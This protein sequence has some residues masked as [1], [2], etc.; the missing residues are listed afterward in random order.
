MNLF[1]WNTT[2]GHLVMARLPGL[3]LAAAMALSDSWLSSN[4]GWV[5]D[6][7]GDP[8]G[9]GE[10]GGDESQAE[11]AD[12]IQ[13]EQLGLY[14]VIMV[15][16][17]VTINVAMAGPYATDDAEDILADLGD[18]IT[19]RVTAALTG[20]VGLVID[21]VDLDA[22]EVDLLQDEGDLAIGDRVDVQAAVVAGDLVDP[23]TVATDAVR[24][25]HA[26]DSTWV[27][28][29][30]FAPNSTSPI[31][32]TV[33]KY[34][35]TSYALLDGTAT[36]RYVAAINKSKGTLSSIAKLEVEE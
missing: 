21:E 32:V 2:V 10:F 24:R 28:S 22:A 9:E 4:G 14:K 36:H 15:S 29:S 3:D 26:L 18:E 16:V 8:E 19:A 35:N 5:P 7:G 34:T 27:A 11:A 25:S 23:A 20:K 33:R 13:E 6:D 1:Q 31:Y 30:A 12:A 17:P